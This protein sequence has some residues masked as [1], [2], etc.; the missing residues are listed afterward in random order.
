MKPSA[1][2]RIRTALRSPLAVTAPLGAALLIPLIP[3]IPAFPQMAAAASGTGRASVLQAALIPV[4]RPLAAG[5]SPSALTGPPVLPGREWPSDLT[6]GA[7]ERVALVTAQQA[8][9]RAAYLR[10]L[11]AIAAQQQ[12]AAAAR[13]RAVAA[14]TRASTPTASAAAPVPV[15]PPAGSGVYSYSALEAL[16][17]SAGGP[18]WAEAS[19]ATIAECESG[20]RVNAYNP[21][22]ASG[23]WQILGSVIPGDLFNPYINAENAVSKFKASG[24]TF[25]QWVCQA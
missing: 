20:G 16:W 23:L 15:P 12:A 18:S 11:A 1:Q 14:A 4:T 3:S 9:V 13:A 19:A 24:N 25:A 17:V 10:Q 21:S 7:Q 5:P 22:G 8:V 6:S 2:E